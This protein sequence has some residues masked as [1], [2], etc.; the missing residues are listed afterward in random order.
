M[1]VQQGVL[2]RCRLS[3]LTNCA[4]VFELK[5]GG[6]GGGVSANEYS[7]AHGAQFGDITPY[8]TYSMLWSVECVDARIRKEL[9]ETYPFI[10]FVAAN[11]FNCVLGFFNW[12]SNFLQSESLFIKNTL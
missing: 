9:Y 5:C 10:M 6:E 11:D 1:T 3:W 4:L 8:L 12:S 2:K 7:C